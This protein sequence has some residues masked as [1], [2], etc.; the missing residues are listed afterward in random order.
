MNSMSIIEVPQN[1][2][3]NGDKNGMNRGGE[4]QRLVG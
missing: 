3:C 2:V 1:R 4:L